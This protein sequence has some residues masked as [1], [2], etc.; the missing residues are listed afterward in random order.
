[1]IRTPGKPIPNSQV[2]TPPD[3]L[4]SWQPFTNV[5]SE[6][7]KRTFFEAL[8]NSLLRAGSPV[9]APPGWPGKTRMESTVVPKV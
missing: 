9:A 2:L 8:A 6:Q 1:M 5:K 7:E 3:S 4:N